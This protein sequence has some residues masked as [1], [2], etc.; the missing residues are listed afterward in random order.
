MQI[1]SGLSGSIWNYAPSIMTF[2]QNLVISRELAGVSEVL[3][4]WSLVE[5]ANAR[6]CHPA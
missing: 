6:L 5:L 1:D 3:C 2:G 4:L